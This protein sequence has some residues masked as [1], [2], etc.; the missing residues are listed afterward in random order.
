MSALSVADIFRANGVWMYLILAETLITYPVLFVGA[1]GFVLTLLGSSRPRLW[2][3]VCAAVVLAPCVL[4]LVTGVLGWHA[5]MQS[6]DAVLKTAATPKIAE[7]FRQHG[8][9]M[10]L[11]PLKFAGLAV[12][13]PGLVGLIFLISG[14]LS[15]NEV[16]TGA[17]RAS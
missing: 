8:E 4:L 5:G 10:A 16:A 6:T 12:I 3:L 17:V 13:L 11:Y 14:L 15:R 7:M 1:L 9:R 2:R